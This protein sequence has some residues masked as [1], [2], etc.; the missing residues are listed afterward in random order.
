[1]TVA[2][3]TPHGARHQGSRDLPYQPSHPDLNETSQIVLE[4]GLS[5][6]EKHE[7]L[8]SRATPH[9]CQDAGY[10]LFLGSS[11]TESS[12]GRAMSHFDDPKSGE[13]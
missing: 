4:K 7:E 3:S 2:E 1:M 9:I 5:T 11:E 13:S 8:P 10:E 6:F 12:S